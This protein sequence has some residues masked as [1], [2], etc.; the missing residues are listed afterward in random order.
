MGAANRTAQN[1]EIIRIDEA[2][3]LILVK[4]AL[5]GAKNGEIVVRP[6]AKAK[7]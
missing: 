4:G 5:P 3:Q 7:K 1:L 6:A 2:R